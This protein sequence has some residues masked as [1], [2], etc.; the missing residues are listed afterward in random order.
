MRGLYA[1]TDSK[2]TPSNLLHGYVKQALLGG[3][4]FIQL[5]DKNAAD[6][7][8]YPDALVL[9][10]ICSHYGAKFIINDRIELASQVKAD[11]VHIG[12]EDMKIAA[13]KEEFSGFV[14]VSC[15][16]DVTHAKKME[17]EGA[18]YVA[19]GSFFLSP[20]KPNAPT[21]S[22]DVIIRAK[23]ELNIP[24]CVIGGITIDNAKELVELGADMVSVISDLWSAE[25]IT[26]RAKD[27]AKLF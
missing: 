27:Y 8:L 5:R 10:S 18:D 24:V 23:K 1:I 21:V 25:S 12:K 9:R 20:T 4:K 26:E 16:G 15:Y 11:G 19:F 6:I 7:E 14:G 2:L 22:K 3:A 17:A 13:V